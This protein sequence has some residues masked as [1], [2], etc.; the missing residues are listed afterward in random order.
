MRVQRASI[1]FGQLP[2]CP[3]C[4]SDRGTPGAGPRGQRTKKR[5]TAEANQSH[6]AEGITRPEH[7]ATTNRCRSEAVG[8]RSPEGRDPA[9]VTQ[10]PL[11]GHW[12]CQRRNGPPCPRRASSARSARRHR[13]HQALCDTSW[14][15]PVD[16]NGYWSSLMAFKRV[17]MDVIDA[18]A[19]VSARVRRR[20]CLTS[21][22]KK[23]RA[24]RDDAAGRV[25]PQ[26]ADAAVP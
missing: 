23:A 9:I 1:P 10:G 15:A 25:L 7:R 4:A 3:A 22:R 18:S 21:L 20:Q 26:Q 19:I 8:K 6:R 24:G 12:R 17:V 14:P 5:M 13:K 16:D 11:D 2:E